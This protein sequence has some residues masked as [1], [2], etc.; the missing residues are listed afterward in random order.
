MDA[1]AI[2]LYIAAMSYFDGIEFL[3]WDDIPRY[4]WF[5]DMRFERHYGLQFHYAGRLVYAMGTRR[6]QTLDG[7]CAWLTGPGPRYRYG[8]PEGETRHH[9]FVQFFGPRTRH[10]L[11]GGLL[12]LP[13]QP[14]RIADA[15]RFYDTMKEL[16]E[17]IGPTRHYMSGS[18][19]PYQMTRD[20]KFH[21]RGSVSD[22]DLATNLLEKLLLLLIKQPVVSTDSPL[23]RKLKALAQRIKEH[24]TDDWSYDTEARAL[25][26]ST[27][28]FRRRFMAVNRIPMGRLVRNFRLEWAA[29][30]LRTTDTAIK[31]LAEKVGA[32][33]VYHFTHLFSERFQLAPGRYRA[34]FRSRQVS[35]P[36]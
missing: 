35:T 36:V 12:E 31:T 17:A 10:M 1:T 18:P 9:V 27:R 33:D 34:A 28:H 16:Q 13:P 20:G 6:L 3:L 7:P 19:L 26:L 8:A 21:L 2:T 29:W 23:D 11:A 25:G 24:P 14:V 4:R 15:E 32:T 30:Q 5:I 22:P